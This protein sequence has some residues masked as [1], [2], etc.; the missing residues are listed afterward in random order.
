MEGVV[1]DDCCKRDKIVDGDTDD[2]EPLLLLIE[3]TVRVGTLGEEDHWP[4]DGAADAN[5]EDEE[6]D[7]G[8]SDEDDCD[9]C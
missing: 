6:E 2:V 5:C 3:L 4:P 1:G 7:G 8:F 9:C